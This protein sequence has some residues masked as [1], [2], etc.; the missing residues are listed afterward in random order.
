[1]WTAM[2][3]HP[4]LLCCQHDGHQLTLRC[5]VV[6]L[7]TVELLTPEGYRP[8]CTVVLLLAEYTTYSHTGRICLHDPL[9]LRIRMSQHRCTSER[10]LQGVEGLLLITTP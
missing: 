1:M 4:P 2:Q 3:V 8:C 10:S 7:G 6:A 5:T 9:S